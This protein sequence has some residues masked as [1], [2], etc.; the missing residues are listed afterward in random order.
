M[1]IT[2]SFKICVDFDATIVKF[3]YPQIG[4]PVPYALET[5]KELIAAGHRIILFTMR[6]HQYL[7]E[8]VTYL[9][10]NGIELYGVNTDPAQKTWTDSPKAHGE[11][12]I[13]DSNLGCPKIWPL[14]ESPYVDWLSI[15]QLLVLEGLI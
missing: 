10:N 3:A 14:D 2:H 13:D 7:E 9:K 6:G 5:I 12:F 4:A 8:A 15:R 11:Y 1:P